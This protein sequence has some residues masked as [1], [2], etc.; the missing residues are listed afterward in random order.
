MSGKMDSSI[1]NKDIIDT[2]DITT[3]TKRK[4]KNKLT[5][6]AITIIFEELTN[7]IKLGNDA[8]F[9]SKL[10]YYQKTVKFNVNTPNEYGNTLLHTACKNRNYEIV[11]ILIDTY[12]AK[13][14]MQNADGR[15]PL[16]IATIYGSTDKAFYTFQNKGAKQQISSS[17]DIINLIVDRFSHVLL[18]RDKDNMTPMN[19]FNTHS[20]IASN[21]SLNNKYKNYKRNI[22]FF[23]SLKVVAPDIS[24]AI[25]FFDSLKVVAPD[26]SDYE[27]SL[28]I[29]F[30]LKSTM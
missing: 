27:L 20:D 22:N 23:D 7:L 13:A 15:T 18:I 8:E 4:T 25:N 21:T 6:D 2:I 24:G 11:N 10:K 1:I 9:I 29:Y 26:I 28:S 3:K 19:Y 14:D 12:N 30:T 5:N 16:H 17:S